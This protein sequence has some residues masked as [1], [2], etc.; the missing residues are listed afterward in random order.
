MFGSAVLS[1]A[2]SAETSSGLGRFLPLGSSPEGHRKDP[3]R[4]SLSCWLS[5]FAR[6]CRE[7]ETHSKFATAS[8]AGYL[9]TSHWTNRCTSIRWTIEPTTYGHFNA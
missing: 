9:V 7:D 1:E 2:S 5:V 4:R 3:C 6:N 8:L